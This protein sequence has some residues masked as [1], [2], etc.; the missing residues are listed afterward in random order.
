[1]IV[2]G[3]GLTECILSGL[4]SVEGK[5]V[6]HMD[7]NDYYG[8]DSASLNLTQVRSMHDEYS[9]EL[10]SHRSCIVNSVQIKQSQQSLVATVTMPSISCPSLLLHLA[11]W[12]RFWFTRMLLDTSS[13][14]RLR[15]ASSIEMAR[16]PKFLAL[17]WKLCEVLWWVYLK[18]GAQRN[19]LSSCKV[20][21]T[22][23][24]LPTKVCEPDIYGH[25]CAERDLGIN[26]D[27]DNMKT[28]YEKFG[29]EP[30]TQDFIGHA[31]A[32]Y[33]DDE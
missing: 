6:L 30:G 15:A 12:R 16:Y 19:F 20:G 22:K 26:L 33:L 3:T 25:F 11:N 18:R 31:M 9:Q 29:L 21:R 1:M 5:K 27:R 2:L 17:R 23:I 13:S 7:R 10:T 24:L 32:L 28:V 8:G 4:L 14:N